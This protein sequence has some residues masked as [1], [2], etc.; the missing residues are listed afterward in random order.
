MVV[1][2]R[3]MVFLRMIYNF[4]FVDLGCGGSVVVGCDCVWFVVV[5]CDVGCEFGGWLKL[6][7]M[8]M[9]DLILGRVFWLI[10]FGMVL[11]G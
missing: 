8:V 2:N 3:V 6:V 10:V 11:R 1:N 5:G 9:C 7:L 4:C